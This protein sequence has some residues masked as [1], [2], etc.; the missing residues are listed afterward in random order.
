MPVQPEIVLL[1]V[2]YEPVAPGG[3]DAQLVGIKE[4]G[5]VSESDGHAVRVLEDLID[6]NFSALNDRLPWQRLVWHNL[7]QWI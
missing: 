7:R 6:G 4:H 1:G 2:C 5:S 3:N